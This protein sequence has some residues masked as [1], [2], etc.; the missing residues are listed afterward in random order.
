MF[1]YPW[2]SGQGLTSF[3]GVNNQVSSFKF[4]NCTLFTGN[5]VLDG[6]Q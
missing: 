5:N 1:E 3:S 2:F 6:I 4:N